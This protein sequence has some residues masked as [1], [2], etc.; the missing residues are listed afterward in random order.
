[1]SLAR[2]L[3]PGH[4]DRVC[5]MIAAAIVEE[6]L[7][8]DPSA[9]LDV[10][11]CGGKGVLFASGDITSSADFD[12][13]AIVR[14]TLT[15]CGVTAPTEPFIAF[16]PMAAAW[17]H[18]HASREPVWVFGYATRRTPS[19]LP[20]G[21][22]LAREIAR[23]LE[24]R[25]MHDAEWYWLGSDYEVWVDESKPFVLIRAEHIEAVAIGDVR[26]SIESF[27]RTLIPEATVLVN[28]AGA[29]CAAGLAHRIG[30]SRQG[31]S[32][33]GYGSALPLHVS[34]IGRHA[35]HPLI[36]GSW[37]TR[38]LACQ[39]VR[40]EKGQ[41]VLV[42]ALWY[43]FESKPRTVR[44]RNEQ[45]RVIAYEDLFALSLADMPTDYRRPSCVVEDVRAAFD[46]DVVLPWEEIQG[47]NV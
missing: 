10:R 42:E 34:G 26:K 2:V 24:A 15:L 7:K 32:V 29:E 31:S 3:G 28:E 41:A 19:L 11:V 13:S 46:V 47:R 16:E 5:D 27:V 25:R 33:D 39:L 1:M 9:R 12:V 38:R 45:G 22:H 8:R 40:A 21:V 4:P 6:Y 17:S 20:R 35:T 44:I 30:S 36:G 23:G 43:P 37:L 18:A 14:R